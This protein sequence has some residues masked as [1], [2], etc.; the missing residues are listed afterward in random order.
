MA[1]ETNLTIRKTTKG[2]IPDAQRLDPMHVEGADTQFR[3]DVSVA[4][5]AHRGD[6]TSQDPKLVTRNVGSLAYPP[7]PSNV[8]GRL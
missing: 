3:G 8:K 5:A 7:D 6:A 1:Y 4:A 2:P